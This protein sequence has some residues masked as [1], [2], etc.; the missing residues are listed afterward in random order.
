MY[1]TVCM[2]LHKD[3]MPNLDFHSTV[4]K[5]LT[6]LTQ[7]KTAD[8]EYW[9]GYL[10]NLK[11]SVYPKR[12]K[13]RGS[14]S[15]YFYGN[16]L[17]E[18]S[19]EDTKRLLSGL[20]RE[21][22]IPIEKCSITR[23]D[24]ARNY[25][26]NLIPREYFKYLGYANGFEKYNNNDSVYF[27]NDSMQLCFYDKIKEIKSKNSNLPIPHLNDNLIRYELRFMK[28]IASKLGVNKVE[29]K[30]LCDEGFFTRLKEEHMKMYLQIHKNEH[31]ILDKSKIKSPSDFINALAAWGIHSMSQNSV[32]EQIE[33]LRLSEA[34]KRPE[35][36]SRLYKK[37]SYLLNN[38]SFPHSS[39][40]VEELDSK[41]LN[42]IS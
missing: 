27:R 2:Y 12:V 7:H 21:L 37:I 25:K 6:E 20:S 22:L 16:N 34:F 24:I 3:T 30:L 8:Y 5:N 10:K 19:L 41:I 26:M 17:N 23:L 11:I 29:A 18:L 14:L 42:V 31:Y 33:D 13:I 32:Y 38:Y 40:L 15:K 4:I 28:K 39:L 9:T 1:D 36:Y 35:G